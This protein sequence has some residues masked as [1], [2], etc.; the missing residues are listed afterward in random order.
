MNIIFV[1]CMLY[2]YSKVWPTKQNIKLTILS[3]RGK[4]SKSQ[5]SIYYMAGQFFHNNFKSM[6]L[7]YTLK[8]SNLQ[9]V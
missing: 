8:S 6:K 1:G 5:T 2:K 7:S 4:K 3:V 9:N